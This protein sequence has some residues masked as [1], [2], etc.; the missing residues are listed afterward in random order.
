LGCAEVEKKVKARQIFDEVGPLLEGLDPPSWKINP[1]YKQQ[2][3]NPRR[4]VTCNKMHDLIIEDTMT[5]E[6]IKEMDECKD[7]LMWGC[8]K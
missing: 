6:R 4:C 7:C 5:G 2:P 3:S 8:F 1:D